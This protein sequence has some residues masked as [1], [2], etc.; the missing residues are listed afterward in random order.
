MS[1][2]IGKTQFKKEV[3]ESSNGHLS[4]VQFKTEWSGAC[5]II[6]PVYEELSKCYNGIADF[7]SID[8]EQE[9]GMEK[10]FGVLELPTILFFKNGELVDHVVGL[11]P[12]NTLISKIENALG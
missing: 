12:K 11:T 5:Q 9:A 3:M 10:E 1:H 6:A 7:F 2:T 4:L 8:V